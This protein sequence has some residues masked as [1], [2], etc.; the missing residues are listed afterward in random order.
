MGASLLGLPTP[1]PFLSSLCAEPPNTVINPVIRPP[2]DRLNLVP[3]SDP[4][5]KQDQAHAVGNGQVRR[6]GLINRVK[7]HLINTSYLTH[8]YLNAKRSIPYI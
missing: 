3:G 6:Y 2:C 8:Y 7:D 4:E 1:N 5:I